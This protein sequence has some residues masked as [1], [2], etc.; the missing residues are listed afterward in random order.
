MI[1]Q[2][3]KIVISIKQLTF[4]KKSSKHSRDIRR[5]KTVK[6]ITD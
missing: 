3:Q 4:P 2:Q 5:L 6:N 1:F